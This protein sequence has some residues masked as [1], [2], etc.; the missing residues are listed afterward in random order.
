MSI[1]TRVVVVGAGAT[2]LAAASQL[3]AAAIDCAVLESKQVG[4]G[5]TLRSAGVLHSGARYAVL[6][7]STAR[8]C[9]SAQNEVLKFAGDTITCRAEAYYLV[10]NNDDQPYAERLMRAC[11]ALGIPARR[12]DRDEV[13]ANE[14]ILQPTL[15]GAVAVP[16]YVQDPVLLLAAYQKF[17]GD[18][19]VP[20]LLDVTIE[21]IQA[22][23]TGWLL[24]T[25]DTN[26]GDITTVRSEAI[27]LAAGA[28]TPDLL[29]LFGINFNV[30]YAK[31]SMFVSNDRFVN[32]VVCRCAP[33]NVPDS[34]IPCYD[35]TL[36]GS[37][38]RSQ[39]NP[40][41][42]VP[43]R[44]ELRETLDH[45]TPILPS[46][47][48]SGINHGYSGV[49]V[50]VNEQT[51]PDTVLR[52]SAKHNYYLGDHTGPSTPSLISIFGGK[53]TLH[54]VMARAAVSVVCRKLA[55]Q[56]EPPPPML[57]IEHASSV[58]RAH[59]GSLRQSTPASGGC[60]DGRN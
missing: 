10:L 54:H 30:S 28:W 4:A 7:P 2:G 57:A 24:H 37:T 6:D 17:L 23:R 51:S 45:L 40:D 55:V 3:A 60:H 49:R 22:K 26:T 36:I 35:T 25:R 21:Q 42:P 48:L 32:R 58:P 5:A 9:A 39:Y 33:P 8:L 53:L 27:V 56:S 47:S 20:I 13:L 50:L 19:R 11:D 16:D 1:E 12:I 14:P 46:L 38:W 31:G 15:I 59:L 29:R 43:D 44:R 41:P 52:D 34:V 18:W